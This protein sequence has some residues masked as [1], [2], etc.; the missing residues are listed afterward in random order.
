MKLY[1]TGEP[2]SQQRHCYYVEGSNVSFIVDC[3]YQRCYAGD[4]IPHL[5]SEQIRSA[6][7]LFL[8][9]SHENQ[10]G[11]LMHLLTNGFTGRVVL[12]AETAQQI[13]IPI[14]DPI[15]L[16]GLSLPFTETEL[17]G[18]LHLIWGRSGHCL[19]SAWFRIRA[20][21]KSILFSGD[22]YPA[23]RIHATD[24]IAGVH[25]DVAVLD[26]DYG[27]Q[28][29]DTREEQLDAL[30]HA[31]SEAIK[32]GRPV[33]LPVPTYGRGLGIMA[34]ISER[35]PDVDIFADEPLRRELSQ[36]DATAMWVRPEAGTLLSS[37]FVRPIPEEFVAL[38]VYLISDP[39][40][41]EPESLILLRQLLICG[42][43][44]IMT[45]TV[46]VG[47]YAASLMHSGNARK[48][49]YAVH[50][51]QEEM[52]AVAAQNDF[53]RIIAYRSDY[54]PTQSVYEI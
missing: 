28:S 40:L 35:L 48:L 53:G 7:Y 38:G 27:T 21:E 29:A 25:A 18:G 12:T 32:D 24:A 6:R 31:I 42:A 52:L 45:G 43:R 23:A 17:P 41:D 44:V 20:G 54:A 49:R 19:G 22:Y 1:L 39:Q 16:E 10:S 36:L 13:H 30:V 33:L 26:C 2:C 3:G 11:G 5:T 4:E 34:C 47:T 46:E 14:D 50:C 9:H 51:T 8:T 15:I 37:L